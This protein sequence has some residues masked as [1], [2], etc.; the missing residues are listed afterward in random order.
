[1]ANRLVAAFAV[2]ILLVSCA[3]ETA[4]ELPVQAVGDLHDTMT[5]VLDPAADVIWGSAGWVITSEGARDLTPTTEEGWDRV[6]HSAAVVAE[7]GNLLLMPHLAPRTDAEAWTE[8]SRG[9]TRV[10]QEAL[11]AVDA[12]DSDALFESGGH[13]YNVCL[14]CHQVYARGEE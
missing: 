6:R 3:K 2:A 11:T 1:M 8:F 10:A 5:W 14:A 12:K 9:M 7:G 13:L 4:D